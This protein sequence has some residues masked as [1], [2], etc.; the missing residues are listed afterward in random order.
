MDG[1]EQEETRTTTNQIYIRV[2]V[3][4]VEGLLILLFQP[5]PSP[6]SIKRLFSTTLAGQ[7]NRG[8]ISRRSGNSR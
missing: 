1:G 8:K 2:R 4:W 3:S 7:T 5:R 6:A